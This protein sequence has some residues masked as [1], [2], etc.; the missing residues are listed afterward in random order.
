MDFLRGFLGTPLQVI[1]FIASLFFAVVIYGVW[2]GRIV[3]AR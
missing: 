2:L 1:L 3:R